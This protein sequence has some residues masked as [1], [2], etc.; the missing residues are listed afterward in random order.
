MI[1]II[2][3]IVISKSSKALTCRRSGEELHLYHLDP[4]SRINTNINIYINISIDTPHFIR[5]HLNRVVTR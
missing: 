4:T 3:N 2:N 1:S 5:A